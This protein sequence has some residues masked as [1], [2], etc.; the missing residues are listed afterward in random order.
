MNKKNIQQTNAKK[1]II[2]KWERWA[3]KVK[4]PACEKIA[5]FNLC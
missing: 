5:K 3:E 1:K 2:R 4:K